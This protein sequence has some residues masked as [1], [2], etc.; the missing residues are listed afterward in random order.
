MIGGLDITCYLVWNT[1][2]LL[3]NREL[4][5]YLKENNSN[6]I[7]RAI[8]INSLKGTWLFIKVLQ[9]LQILFLWRNSVKIR[10]GNQC[11]STIFHLTR[12]SWKNYSVTYVFLSWI[13]RVFRLRIC[14]LKEVQRHKIQNQIYK[15]QSS[16]V[17]WSRGWFNLTHCTKER[18]HKQ[19]V[20]PLL[21]L[22]FENKFKDVRAIFSL[23]L[24]KAR[25]GFSNFMDVQ[26]PILSWGLSLF[27]TQNLEHSKS[28]DA[29]GIISIYTLTVC[30]SLS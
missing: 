23:A 11:C 7:E 25:T 8:E 20:N 15:N 6:E 14:S 5:N 27:Q 18:S 28:K 24:L 29:L 26:I 22:D 13:T 16:E 30:S 3:I 9:F 4:W 10:Q 12:K 21:F 19:N 17:F 2:H 1:L